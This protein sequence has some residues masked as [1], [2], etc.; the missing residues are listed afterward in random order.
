[1]HRGHNQP[2]SKRQLAIPQ[3]LTCL[4]WS[5]LEAAAQAEGFS[6]SV[7]EYWTVLKQQEKASATSSTDIAEPKLDWDDA[8]VASTLSDPEEDQHPPGNQSHTPPLVRQTQDT[9]AHSLLQFT[10]PPQAPQSIKRQARNKTF[11]SSPL[12]CKSR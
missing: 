5:Q 11:P 9:A 2:S 7:E 8:D 6:G 1:M 10:T 3:H 12:L 4:V